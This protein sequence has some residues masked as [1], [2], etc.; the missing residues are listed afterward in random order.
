MAPLKLL[1]SPFT[2]GVGILFFIVGLFRSLFSGGSVG[3]ASGVLYVQWNKDD[4]EMNSATTLG[5]T[6]LRLSALAASPPPSPIRVAFR[7]FRSGL[8][9]SACQAIE[10]G[11]LFR[12]SAVPAVASPRRVLDAGRAVRAREPETPVA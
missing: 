5:A 1:S 9:P 2:T 3:F 7:Q 12:K 10:L 6:N 8:Y 4:A 11:A